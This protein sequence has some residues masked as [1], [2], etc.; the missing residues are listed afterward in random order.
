MKK[1]F[2]FAALIPIILVLG[3]SEVFSVA[4]ILYQLN[5]ETAFTDPYPVEP[6][7]N[8]VLSLTLSNSGN[9]DATDVTIEL[10]VVE[11]FTLL[12]SSQKEI[13]SVKV[14]SSRIF[15]YQLFVDSSAVSAL[16]E[17]PVRVKYSVNKEL[18][19][20]VQVRV[21]GQPKFEMLDVS[22]GTISPGDQEKIRVKLQNVGTGKAKRTSVTFSSTSD[23]VKS[24][25]SG[26]IA[27]LGDVNPGEEKETTFTLLA[28]PDSEYGIC[29][30]KINVT[31]DDES[32]NE[33]TESFDVGILISGIP[34]LQVYKIDV[35]RE[36]SDLTVEIVNIGNAEAKAVAAKLLINDKVFDVDYVTSIKIDR[37]STLKFALPNSMSG[38]LELSYEGPDNKEYSQTEDMAWVVAYGFPTWIIVIVV[39]VV[40]YFV[41]KKKLWK[42]IF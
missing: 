13:T 11:P 34:K 24:V 6:G 31:Y 38:K 10:E 9:T 8:L 39:L 32:G 37:R 12:E 2:L 5:V 7:K 1:M 29:T 28:S 14:G 15:D 19:K 4:E 26:G 17:I 18:I 25:L 21:Q 20:K 16:Y 27:Y 3:L 42:K 23:Y 40:A 36:D 22:S 33:L 30:G 35:D 41:W